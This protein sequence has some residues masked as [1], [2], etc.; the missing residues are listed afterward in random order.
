[1][2]YAICVLTKAT[3]SVNKWL[4][5]HHGKVDIGDRRRKE[6]FVK[7]SYKVALSQMTAAYQSTKKA[8]SESE[9]SCGKN[10]RTYFFQ[11]DKA[12]EF[13]MGRTQK[14]NIELPNIPKELAVRTKSDRT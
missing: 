1:M 14:S 12:G 3:F 6:G 7:V 4:Y 5:Y 9:G 2:F 10:L 11:M 8:A 13:V